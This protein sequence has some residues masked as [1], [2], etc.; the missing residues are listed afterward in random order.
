MEEK[1]FLATLGMV[2][3][4]GFMMAFY[5]A[6]V[7]LCGAILI[8]GGLWLIDKA[9]GTSW[10]TGW[11]KLLDRADGWFSKD[12]VLVVSTKTDKPNSKVQPNGR[13]G[14]SPAST[15]KGARP[16]AAQKSGTARTRPA[17][18]PAATASAARPTRPSRAVQ[19]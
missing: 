15:V 6:V 3:T 10:S 19:A 1:S 11:N 13:S 8:G 17:Q 7:I 5:Y 9:L 16:Q 18:A 12:E 4:T 14:K 2:I